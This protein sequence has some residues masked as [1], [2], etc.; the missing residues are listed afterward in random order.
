MI[1]YN[2]GPKKIYAPEDKSDRRMENMHNEEIRNFYFAHN[3]VREI[4]SRRIR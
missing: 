4:E 1:F 3:I 2:Q